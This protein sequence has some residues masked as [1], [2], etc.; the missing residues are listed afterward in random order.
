MVP[1]DIFP[2]LVGNYAQFLAEPLEV[3]YNDI[4]DTFQWPLIWRNEYI[5]VI[6]KCQ[7]PEDLGSCRNISCTNLFSKI[8]E[9]FLLEWSWEQVS[10]NMRKNQFG[11][12]K[13]CGTEHL[14]VHLWTGIL[15]NLED[16][17]GCCS[18]ISLDFAKAFNRLD[19][20]HIL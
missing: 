9:S 8:L 19:H 7:S 10:P 4:I 17:R 20:T 11:G 14:L 16:S 6:P 3:I 13:G 18:L 5:T 12:Q 15:D 2:Q 1:G